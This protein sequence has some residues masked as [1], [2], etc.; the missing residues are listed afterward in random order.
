MNKNDLVSLCEDGR[1]LDF[2]PE[3]SLLDSERN[4]AQ[5]VVLGVYS[6][7]FSLDNWTDKKSFY[8]FVLSKW[9]NSDY[10][11][12]FANVWKS[13]RTYEEILS[14]LG[15]VFVNFSEE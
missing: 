4:C 5:F 12:D 3:R 2:L 1:N 9:S 8:S 6:K 10:A 13:I 7:R 11:K 15:L 14:D